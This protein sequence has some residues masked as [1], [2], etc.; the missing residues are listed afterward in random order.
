MKDLKTINKER[1]GRINLSQ[2]KDL[3]E[4]ADY[5]TPNIDETAFGGSHVNTTNSDPKFT[6]YYPKGSD[7]SSL[8]NHKG[9]KKST[10]IEYEY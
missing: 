3:I 8:M 2:H 7:Y 10:F 4:I 1:E 9:L 5:Y 6:I